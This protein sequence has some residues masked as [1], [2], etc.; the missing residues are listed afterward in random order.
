MKCEDASMILQRPGAGAERER[1]AAAEHL[2][3]CD[4]CRHAARAIA[5]LSADGKL[6]IVVPAEYAFARAIAAATTRA[7]WAP[8]TMPRRRSFVLGV[9]VGAALAAG[10]AVAAFMLRPDETVVPAGAPAVLLSLNEARDISVALNSPEP[11]ADAEIRVALS[12]AIGLK[13]FA[14]RRELHWTTDL[15]RGVNQLTLPIVALGVGGG[16]VLVEVQH[17]DKRRTFIVDVRTT[18]GRPSAFVPG[19][20][21]LDA[22]SERKSI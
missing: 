12:G 1:R 17:G 11:L 6:P 2:S 16:Q 15:D 8:R 4:D 9:G 18:S 14:E 20:R 10:I 13:G 19:E 22:Q 21:S 5:A 7:A 3:G